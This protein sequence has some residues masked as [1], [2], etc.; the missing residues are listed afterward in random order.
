MNCIHS[1]F[2]KKSCLHKISS[3]AIR[4]IYPLGV[5]AGL[6]EASQLVAI[7]VQVNCCLKIAILCKLQFT[8]LFVSVATFAADKKRKN[9]LVF[10]AFY[11]LLNDLLFV[12]KKSVVLL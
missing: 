5:I 6:T 8:G 12:L 1:A 3:L 2:K 10:K 7:N 11:L 9:C 4:N